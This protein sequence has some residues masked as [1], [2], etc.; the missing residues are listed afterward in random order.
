MNKVKFL[1]IT[2]A[3]IIIILGVLNKLNVIDKFLL[4][5]SVVIG[6]ILISILHIVDGYFS[7]IK[8]KKIDGVIWFVLGIFFI[9]LST[10]VYSF[11]H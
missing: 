4:A 5:D 10:F 6:F 8:N 7:F 9:Y 1:K 3:V 2:I 11:W